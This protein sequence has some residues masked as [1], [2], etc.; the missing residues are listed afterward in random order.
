MS[1][2]YEKLKHTIG[3]DPYQ[4]PEEDDKNLANVLTSLKPNAT[5]GNF[6]DLLHT[7]DNFKRR[8]AMKNVARR[9][10][11]ERKQEAIAKQAKKLADD[12]S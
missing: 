1:D 6:R 5:P 11:E 9:L 7:A 12:L 8:L 2:F 3:I 10:H 4:K